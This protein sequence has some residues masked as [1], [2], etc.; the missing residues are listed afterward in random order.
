MWI[1]LLKRAQ[2]VRPRLLFWLVKPIAHSLILSWDST[3]YS[4]NLNTLV[5]FSFLNCAVKKKE[6][7]ERE[8]GLQTTDYQFLLLP[9]LPAG[10]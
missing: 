9:T 10:T 6:K 1:K 4:Y 3:N 5:F 2:L 7:I 8:D